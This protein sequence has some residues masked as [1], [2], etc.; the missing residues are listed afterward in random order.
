MWGR[1]FKSEQSKL[2]LLFLIRRGEK[3]VSFSYKKPAMSSE[4]IVKTGIN[5][6]IN[7]IKISNYERTNQMHGSHKCTSDVIVNFRGKK[8]C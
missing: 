2:K 7:N 4:T 5:Q 6:I 8:V 3:S 1:F